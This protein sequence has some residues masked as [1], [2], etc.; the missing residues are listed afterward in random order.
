MSPDESFQ[1][2]DIGLL[3]LKTAVEVMEEETPL[4]PN[5]WRVGIKWCVPIITLNCGRRSMTCLR[6]DI[7]TGFVVR[8]P[9]GRMVHARGHMPS[10]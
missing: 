9:I 5:G 3:K 2:R 4:K 7:G 6:L 1:N 8:F 10:D